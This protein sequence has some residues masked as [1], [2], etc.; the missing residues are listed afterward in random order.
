MKCCSKHLQRLFLPFFPSMKRPAASRSLGRQQHR[1]S[2][3]GRT[4]GIESTR[5]SCLLLRRSGKLI[6]QVKSLKKG[7]SKMRKGVVRTETKQRKS[8]QNRNKDVMIAR[9]RRDYTGKRQSRVPSPAEIRRN[10][11][12]EQLLQDT[13]TSEECAQKWLLRNGFAW[14]PKACESCNGKAMYNCLREQRSNL[15]HWRCKNCGRRH[16]FNTHTHCYFCG[17]RCSSLHVI[18]LLK[19]Y[20]KEDQSKVPYVANLVQATHSSKKQAMHFIEAMRDMESRAG[21]LCAATLKLSGNVEC[22]GTSLGKFYVGQGC[23]RFQKEILNIQQKE[24]NAGRTPP[25]SLCVHIQCLG[26]F[27]RAGP[28][29]LHLSGPRAS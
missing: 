25:K 8:K 27:Q 7:N 28:A 29:V 21:T 2:A 10:I 6:A 19:A 15:P 4:R 26:A 24:I 5:V 18:K 22:D 1:C 16:Y 12:D 20:V 14:K 3:C 9:R 13:L 23:V 17:L 11:P